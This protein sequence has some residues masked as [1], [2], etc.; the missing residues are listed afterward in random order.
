MACNY[1]ENATIEDSSC[2]YPE[3]YFNCDGTCINDADGDGVCDEL[4]VL[5]CTEIG[6]PGYNP[7]ATE[8]DGSCLVAGC[9]L[10]FA[11]NY[12]PNADY[13]IVSLCDFSS[14][15][16]CTDET[17]CNYDANA[18]LGSA[19]ACDYPSVPF[20]DCDGNCLNDADGDGVCDEQEIPGCTDET[21]VNFNPFATDDNGTCIVLQG[22]CV[23]PFACNYD[24]SA[25]FYLPGSCD[26]SCLFS[27]AEGDCNNEMA[28]NYGAIDEPCVFFDAQGNTCVP[29]GCTIN[30]ACNYDAAAAYNDGS[31]EFAT[32]Q[33]FGCNVEAACNYNAD[34]TVN[35]GSCDFAT[36]FNIETEGCTNPMA[37]NYSEEATSND[38]SCEFLSCLDMGCTD[39]NACNYD[40]NAT[41]NDGSCEI[42]TDGYDCTGEC[43]A[44]ADGDGVCDANEV[45]GCT[46]MGAN[47][48]DANATDNNG[49]CTYDSEGCMNVNACNFNFQATTDNGSCA[50]DCYGCMNE[51]ACNYD[52]SASMHDAGECSYIFTL[53]LEGD[54]EVELDQP[55]TYTYTPTAGSDYVWTI[56]GGAI[57][58][59]EGTNEVSVV[60]MLEEG[61]IAVYEINSDGCIGIETILNVTG[62]RTETGIAEGAADFTIYPNPA[63]DML[64]VNVDGFV[65]HGMQVLDATGRVVLSERLVA[66]RNVI[67][68]TSLANGT[69][70]F[71]INEG[72]SRQVKQL[73]IAH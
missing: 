64:I 15:V 5:G 14:C 21:A 29:G 66:G 1:D 49:T 57:V 22:G 32:C 69:Y 54:T 67:D 26:F 51:N 3:E 37:C 62:S 68:V 16:G 39:E 61:S 42:A 4:E 48:Y 11:C 28:C 19:S 47:N 7:S 35:D 38:G 25:D 59:G 43:V 60:W 63:N 71:V 23:L 8:D 52:A 44:D 6:N 33:V 31:C 56:V 20:L 24:A 10:P 36:C 2:E 45:G 58:E 9:L 27:A 40:A 50:F 55:T 65:A 72:Q 70:K 12:D 34:A 73:I 41:I 13:I 18:T 46:D 53:E 30:G 17:A